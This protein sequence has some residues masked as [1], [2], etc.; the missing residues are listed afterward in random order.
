M[1]END[2]SVSEYT[3]TIN[4]VE[5]TLQLTEEDAKRYQERDGVE[6]GSKAATPANKSRSTASK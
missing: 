3:V 5:H 4:G 6:V 2:N 1:A